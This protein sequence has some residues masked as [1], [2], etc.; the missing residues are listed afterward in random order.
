M[1]SQNSKL[2]NSLRVVFM[3]TPD[4]AVKTLSQIHFHSL[5]QV[6]GVVTAPDK[7]AGR[8]RQLSKSAVKEFAETHHLPLWQPEKLKDSLFIE[9][10]SRL[11][12]DVIVVVAFRMLPEVVW[13]I[14][15]LGTF[16][17]HASLLPQYR[18][19]APINWALINGEVETGVTTFLIDQQIDTGHILL[20][21]K[22]SIAPTDT[23]G[24]LYQKLADMGA[25]LACETLNGLSSGQI[26][27]KTQESVFHLQSAP[28]LTVENTQIDWNEAP[29]KI[30]SL[31]RGLNP[32]PKA[33]TMLYNEGKILKVNLLR[34]E[35]SS[36][37][38]PEGKIKVEGKKLFVG[39][40]KESIEINE[41]QLPGKKIM[42]V[43][44]LLNGFSFSNEA[45]FA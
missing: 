41:I 36:L 28:K 18:G 16:N 40:G 37:M 24:T 42:P 13:K 25:V 3:G 20:Q 32:F 38:L 45:Y 6:V 39:T 7:P 14:P 15:R 35:K 5:H 17:V 33:W 10:M 43:K 26:V 21:Q 11:A 1:S 29:E 8:G 19:A 22:I 4:F 12:P 44:D 23:F 9:E 30:I 31:I 27:P 2:S 34:A